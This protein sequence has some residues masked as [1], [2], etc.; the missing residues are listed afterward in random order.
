MV[1]TGVITFGSNAIQITDSANGGVTVPTRTFF[2]RILIEPLR[3]NTHAAYVGLSNVTND[4]S[5][6]GVIQ[7]LAAPATGV[8]LDR[9]LDM[10]AGSAHNIPPDIY[11]VHGF[12]GEKAKVS[13]FGI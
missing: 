3:T 4:G 5:G 11:Y 10:A 7:E 12:S 1:Y 8:A 6:T 9:F 13:V 2:R